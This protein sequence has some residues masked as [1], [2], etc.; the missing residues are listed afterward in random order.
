MDFSDFKDFEFPNSSDIVYIVYFRK[1]Y[2]NSEVPFYVGMSTKHIGRFGDY[3]SANYSAPTDY[4]VGKAIQ[5]MRDFGLNVGIKYKETNNYKEEEKE[6]INKLRKN[7][8]LINDLPGFDYK[9]A[10]ENQEKIKI[11]EFVQQLIKK[12]H[13]QRNDSDN[14]NKSS[15]AALRQK[16]RTVACHD[17]EKSKKMINGTVAIP[18]IYKTDNQY[19]CELLISKESSDMLPHEYE[20]KKIIEMTIGQMLYEAGVHETEKGVVWISA[21]LHTKGRKREKVRLVDALAEV[22]LQ[23]GDKVRITINSNGSY[24]LQAK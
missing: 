2:D 16:E 22:G 21:V 18:G 10:N 6:L 4:K 24:T 9:R 13:A 12:I 14:D 1:P 8:L 23:N 3:L 20:K 19:R 7:Y 5:Y 17:N 11:H 15:R